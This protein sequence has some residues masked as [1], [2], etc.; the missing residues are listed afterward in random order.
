MRNFLIFIDF[1]KKYKTLLDSVE[2]FMTWKV[3]SVV[4]LLEHRTLYSDHYIF[5][6]NKVCW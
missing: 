6:V 3:R 2:P 1:R 5:S 4:D